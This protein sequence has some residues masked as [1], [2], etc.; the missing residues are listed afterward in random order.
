MGRRPM[1]VR[2][3]SPV[4]SSVVVWTDKSIMVEDANSGMVLGRE[5]KEVD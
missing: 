2:V 4:C 1:I 5:L 3:A